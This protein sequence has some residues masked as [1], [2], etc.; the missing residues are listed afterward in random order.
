M[1]DQRFNNNKRHIVSNL[2]SGTWEGSVYATL[3]LPCEGRDAVSDR[4]S[5][6]K[7]VCEANTTA[8]KSYCC[9]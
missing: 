1:A 9:C 6:K 4:P 5:A 7:L 2:I 3:L 8:K